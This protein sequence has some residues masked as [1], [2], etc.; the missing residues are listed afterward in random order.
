MLKIIIRAIQNTK[1]QA[2]ILLPEFPI[3]CFKSV[4]SG[5][6]QSKMNLRQIQSGLLLWLKVRVGN[7]S[8]DDC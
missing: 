2:F 3:V 4:V 5:Y 1:M 7:C 6:L 8:L